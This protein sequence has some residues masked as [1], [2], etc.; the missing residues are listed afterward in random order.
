M[1]EESV[2]VDPRKREEAACAGG[3]FAPIRAA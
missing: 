1:E 3:E 2:I